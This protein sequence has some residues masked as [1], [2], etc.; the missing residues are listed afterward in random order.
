[1]KDIKAEAMFQDLYQTLWCV[2]LHYGK[3][4]EEVVQ[5]V[6]DEIANMEW[7]LK[8]TKTLDKEGSL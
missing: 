7:L 8:G 3:S 4:S 5:I 1:M 6:R 2:E